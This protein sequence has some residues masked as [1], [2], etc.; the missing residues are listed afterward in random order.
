MPFLLRI[1]PTGKP[2]FVGGA[3]EDINSLP[4]PELVGESIVEKTINTQQIASVGGYTT[5]NGSI[6]AGS[7]VFEALHLDTQLYREALQAIDPLAVIHNTDEL[8]EHFDIFDSER[9]GNIINDFKI[10]GLNSV[11]ILYDGTGWF[12]GSKLRWFFEDDEVKVVLDGEIIA[13]SGLLY[14]LDIEGTLSIR[15][16][17]L[18]VSQNYLVD[19]AGYK[20]ENNAIE[21]F[22]G[23]LSG[24]V[25]DNQ[26]IS[27]TLSAFIK[28][29]PWLPGLEATK[30]IE[31]STAPVGII[32]FIESEFEGPVVNRK[33]IGNW[34]HIFN[35]FRSNT[36]FRIDYDGDS[37]LQRFAIE[38]VFDID[39]GGTIDDTVGFGWIKNISEGDQ[40][41]Y[42]FD[43]VFFNDDIMVDGVAT[44]NENIIIP[45]ATTN[46]HA[47]NRI[48][49]DG[50]YGRLAVANTYAENQT[51]SAEGIFNGLVRFNSVQTFEDTAGTIAATTNLVLINDQAIIGYTYTLPPATGS[52]R[53]LIIKDIAGSASIGHTIQR[54]G[55]D[56]IDGA[57]TVALDTDY[58]RIILSDTESGRW[59]VIMRQ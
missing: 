18:I 4:E 38:R 47:V 24:F 45:N 57:T 49:G 27:K 6:R 35:N 59:S 7:L 17:G 21:A 51:F 15:D 2:I 34:G 52:R 36:A 37:E 42:F 33:S 26:K 11:Q 43:D 9:V 12:A 22:Q 41:W 13:R 39:S 23:K 29:A 3:A 25:F 46:G 44:F 14:D 20:L 30:T 50:R 28:P 55:S 8:D 32:E 10:D 48:T 16:G 19:E 31:I 56:N 40:F 5:K 58:G 1:D 53:I 54:A